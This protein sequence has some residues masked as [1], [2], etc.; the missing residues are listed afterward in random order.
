MEPPRLCSVYAYCVC[1]A[2]FSCQSQGTT[3]SDESRTEPIESS[4]R[5]FERSPLRNGSLQKLHPRTNLTSARQRTSNSV[6]RAFVDLNHRRWQ[7]ASVRIHTDAVRTVVEAIDLLST[8]SQR[9]GLGRPICTYFALQNAKRRNVCMPNVTNR[10]FS[11]T[12]QMTLDD[13]KDIMLLLHREFT[14]RCPERH[15]HLG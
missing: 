1:C 11:D 13:E 9:T 6:V 10:A 14:K 4:G 7:R 8:L 2:S 12:I 5:D 15:K 3:R